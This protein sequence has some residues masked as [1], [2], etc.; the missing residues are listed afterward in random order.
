[1]A[2][3]LIDGTKEEACRLA[4]ANAIR[5]KTGSSVAIAYDWANNKGFADA[6]AAIEG[7]GAVHPNS[8]WSERVTLSSASSSITFTLTKANDP[9]AFFV[10]YDGNLSTGAAP[11]KTAFV[12]Y[13]GTD[14]VGQY[15]TN[16]NNAQMTYNSS[17]WSKTYS[18]GSLTIT[19]SNSN[20]QAGTYR[21]L[22]FYG[23]TK[24]DIVTKSVQVGSGATS[25]TF[26]DVDAY[27]DILAGECIVYFT[28]SFGTS[29]G[30]SRVAWVDVYLDEME[31]WGG[32]MT[33]Q[34]SKTYNWSVS[35]S[36][37][38]LV[39]TSSSASSGGY[40]HQPGYYTLLYLKKN[41]GSSELQIPDPW[42]DTT[43]G[44]VASTTVTAL[45]S[46]F[47]A[48]K[49]GRYRVNAFLWRT[50]TSGT[51]SCQIYINGTA[52]TYG[53][54]SWNGNR[55]TI[56]SYFTL[57]EDDVV[58]VRGSSRGTSYTL[59]LIGWT[60]AYADLA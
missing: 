48:E 36:N 32:E 33:D 49:G 31:T 46:S 51:W 3:M 60:A 7:G 44:S 21:L 30:Y 45:G 19:G 39:L 24:S 5:A 1:M 55:G 28:S 42:V 57:A 13:D 35:L 29:Y 23:G 47:T 58:T 11:Y 53:S 27:Q 56:S 4:E 40:F 37:G 26:T 8:A 38:N 14:I 59:W 54:V 2:T 15:I 20:F 50:N 41:E 22:Y 16:T 18:N 52:Q 10:Y 17:G 12:A 43:G 6:I 25:I 34:L 9:V